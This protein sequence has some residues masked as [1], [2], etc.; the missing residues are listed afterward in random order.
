[1]KNGTVVFIV[2]PYVRG[3]LGLIL[4]LAYNVL[5]KVPFLVFL[6]PLLV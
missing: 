5:A 6:S 2:F 1:M 4:A 3:V